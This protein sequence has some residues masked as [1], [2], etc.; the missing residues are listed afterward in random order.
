MGASAITRVHAVAKIMVA[1]VIS[2]IVFEAAEEQE[3]VYSYLRCSK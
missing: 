3:Q 1:I 2:V